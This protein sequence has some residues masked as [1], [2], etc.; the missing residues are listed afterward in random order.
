M[1]APAH[2]QPAE[3]TWSEYVSGLAWG[4]G[5]LDVASYDACLRAASLGV[6]AELALREITSRI[7]AAGVYPRPGK[8]EQQW[9]RAA[10]YVN[11]NPNTPILELVRRP[12]FDPVRATRFAAR[13]SAAVNINWLKR[14][15]P[16]P[17]SITPAE[18]LSVVFPLGYKVLVFTDPCSQGQALYQNQ[19]LKTDRSA[20]DSFIIGHGGGVWFLSNPVSGE[21][22]FNPRQ[23]TMSRRSE[24]SLTSFRHAVLESDCQPLDQWLRILVQLPLPIVSITSSGGKSLHALLLINAQSKTAWDQ[25]VRGGLL[26]R[27]VPFGADPQAMTAIRLTRLP[28]C[29]RGDRL[30]QLLYLNPAASAHPVLHK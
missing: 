18:Y 2:I 22:H 8:L 27:L 4:K 9:R 14:Q 28:A 7:R 11:V 24:E 3:Q 13:V 15:S 16:V 1:S 25:L 26:P 5:N 30:Q 20:L 19:S 23:Q 17:T 21:Y 10:M 6:P 29:Y 12:V